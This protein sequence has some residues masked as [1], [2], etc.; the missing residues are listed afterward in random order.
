MP[1]MRAV[2]QKAGR[3]AQTKSLQGSKNVNAL[4]LKNGGIYQ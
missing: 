2:S 4:D 1:G 3:V